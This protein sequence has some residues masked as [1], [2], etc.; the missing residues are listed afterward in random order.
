M[1]HLHPLNQQLSHIFHAKKILQNNPSLFQRMAFQTP[2]VGTKTGYFEEFSSH[3]KY[4]SVVNLGDVDGASDAVIDW[5]S[6]N[7]K[8]DDFSKNAQQYISNN[9]S[10][11]KEVNGI[12]EA[13][14]SLL[15]NKE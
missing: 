5:L 9:Y 12:I 13:Y 6:K 10:I 2:F 7:D 4:G 11:E 14:K 1:H 8:L 15:D 3:G